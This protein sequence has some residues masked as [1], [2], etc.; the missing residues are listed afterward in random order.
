MA[1]GPVDEIGLFVAPAHDG[2]D[3]GLAD[4]TRLKMISAESM[5]HGVGHLRYTGVSR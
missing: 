4:K 3:G 1:S 5:A 2:R